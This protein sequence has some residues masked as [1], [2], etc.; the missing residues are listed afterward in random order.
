MCNLIVIS[1]EVP[2]T[3][4]FRIVIERNI[5]I[6]EIIEI[7]IPKWRIQSK[8]VEVILLGLSKSGCVKISI[9]GAATK[10]EIAS[11]KLET[12]NSVTIMNKAARL[13]LSKLRMM[14]RELICQYTL[15]VRA[16]LFI[17]NLTRFRHLH[18]VCVEF[19]FLFSHPRNKI[20]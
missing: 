2:D 16:G 7:G 5:A 9:T 15:E 17:E 3:I 10:S 8:T 6:T 18:I 19:R 12:V 1:L 20:L 4:L 13:P 11:M 14:F